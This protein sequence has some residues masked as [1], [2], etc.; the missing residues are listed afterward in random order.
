LINQNYHPKEYNKSLKQLGLFL[1]CFS[2]F[3]SIGCKRPDESLGENLQPID[4]RLHAAVT[5]SFQLEMKTERVD[6]LRTDLF[7]NILVGNYIDEQFGAVK[8]RGVM[9]FAPDLTADTLPANREVFAVEL[10]L[11]YQ[12]EAYGNNAPMYFQVQQLQEPIYL[13]S[14]YYNHNLPQRNLQ[15]LI[16]SGQETHLTRSEYSSALSSGSIE[17]LTLNLQPSL[18]Q[19][20]LANSEALEDFDS[21]AQ[22]FN[23]LVIS[24]NTMDGR[25]VSFSTIY[26]SITVYYR[27]PGEDRMN[28]G[29]YTFKYTSSCEAYSVVEHQYYGS[30]LQSLTSANPLEGNNTAYLQGGGGTRVRLDLNDVLWLRQNPDVVINNAELVVPYDAYSKYALLDSVNVVYEKSD[31]LFSLTADVFRYPGGNFSRR[32]GYYRFNITSHVQSIM[33]GEIDETEL[34]MV[35]GPRVSGLYNSLGV[36]RAS[37]MGPAHG[38][39][40]TMNTRLVVTY[41]Y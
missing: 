37:L 31:G 28:I 10:K 14:A 19:Y 39:D 21:F 12:P 24:S 13:D 18:G 3:F 1:V 27:Y 23:G 25:V 4:D 35:A 9:Q 6:S 20:M 32:P 34:I 11:A 7:A 15:N 41:S 17:Y 16:L 5:D 36:R 33:L 38:V 2:L 30:A 8:C 22:Y 26:S 40:P 29:T